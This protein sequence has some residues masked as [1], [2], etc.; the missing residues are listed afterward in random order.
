M[1]SVVFLF[2]VFV[3]VVVCVLGEVKCGESIP[4]CIYT[5]RCVVVIFN[6][7]TNSHNRFSFIREIFHFSEISNGTA[8][9]LTS[10]EKAAG[11][12]VP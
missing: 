11:T 8:N 10:L 12:V 3:V 7:A 1:F 9:I 2:F 6:F 5:V 4:I